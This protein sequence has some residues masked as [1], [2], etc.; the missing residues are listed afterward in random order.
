VNVKDPEATTPLLAHVQYW[1]NSELH[2]QLYEAA[3]AGVLAQPAGK[4]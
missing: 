1:N 2:Q 3:W 4:P